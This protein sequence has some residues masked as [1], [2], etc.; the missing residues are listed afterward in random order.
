MLDRNQN[1]SI[2]GSIVEGRERGQVFGTITTNYPLLSS[3]FF[4]KPNGM[5]RSFP[6]FP[7]KPNP[8]FISSANCTGIY[9]GNFTSRR[10][11]IQPFQCFSTYTILT[12]LSWNRLTIPFGLSLS[13][14]QV[15]SIRYTLGPLCS[16]FSQVSRKFVGQNNQEAI[17]VIL[18]R[19]SATSRSSALHLILVPHH[20]FKQ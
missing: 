20:S 3:A 11:V 12:S 2:H 10:F 13:D 9:R 15:D 8:S 16:V 14:G 4:A 5:A 7:A 1:I 6:E 17:N 19:V 18:R